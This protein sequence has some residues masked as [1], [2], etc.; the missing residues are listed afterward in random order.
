MLWITDSKYGFYYILKEIIWAGKIEFNIGNHVTA[1]CCEVMGIGLV[2]DHEEFI[3]YLINFLYPSGV[4]TEILKDHTVKTL[5]A[6]RLIGGSR[7]KKES[8]LINFEL[9]EAN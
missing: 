3:Y 8:K 1:V 2:E 4:T 7:I 6:L 9:K 5:K